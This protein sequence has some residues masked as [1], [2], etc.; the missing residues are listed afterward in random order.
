MNLYLQ[1]CFIM[2]LEQVV[3]IKM[4]NETLCLWFMLDI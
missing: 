4:G 3:Y 1:R 2:T